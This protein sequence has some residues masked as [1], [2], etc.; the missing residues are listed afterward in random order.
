MRTVTSLVLTLF[1]ASPA[2]G[3]AAPQRVVVMP[4]EFRVIE[5]SAGGVIEVLPDE[6]EAAKAVYADAVIKR[7]EGSQTYSVV[8]IPE[9]SPEETTLLNEYVSLYSLV[10]QQA[11]EMINSGGWGHKKKAFDYTVGPGLRFLAERA[12]ADKAV[13]TGG[14]VMQSSGGRILLAIAATAAGFSVP[15]G[16]SNLSVSIVD[17]HTGEVEWLNAT[18]YFNGQTVQHD[19]A[20]VL[21]AL[22]KDF[23]SS[24]YHARKL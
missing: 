2:V 12:G 8:R 9:L 16:N 3:Y 11:V 24:S 17:L 19:P 15:T 10:S 21:S 23:P 18:Q 4:V 7:F 20:T 1:L 13:F 14:H 6:T 5:I 22:F